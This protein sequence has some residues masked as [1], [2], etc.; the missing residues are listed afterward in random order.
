MSSPRDRTGVTLIELIVV[1]AILGVTAG[2]VSL[3]FAR[4]VPPRETLTSRLTAARDSALSSG[5]Q[6]LLT[7]VTDSGLVLIAANPDGRVMAEPA[8]RGA[9]RAETLYAR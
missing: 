6:V 5:R 2:V 8:T 1:L 3:S 9:V 4:R 7:I